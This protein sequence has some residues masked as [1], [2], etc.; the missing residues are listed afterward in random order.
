MVVRTI[1][2]IDWVHVLLLLV[3][4]RKPITVSV[5]DMVLCWILVVVTIMRRVSVEIIIDPLVR[6]LLLNLQLR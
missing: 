4:V 3:M 5:N 6:L 2:R 1:T